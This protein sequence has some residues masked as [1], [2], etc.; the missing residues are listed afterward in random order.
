MIQL[1]INVFLDV[2]MINGKNMMMENSI[3]NNVKYLD[4]INMEQKNVQIVIKQ[5]IIFMK[6]NVMILCVGKKELS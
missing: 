5:M 2:M 4:M 3:V 6:K 1:N